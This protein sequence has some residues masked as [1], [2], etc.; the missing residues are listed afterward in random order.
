[1]DKIIAK[2]CGFLSCVLILGVV[3]LGAVMLVP[4]LAGNEVY[5]V[6]SGSMEPNYHVG[7]LVI[8]DK[9]LEPAELKPG[10]AITFRRDTAV[11]THRIV[12]AD[13][14]NQY[15]L[16]KGDA[17][18]VEDAAPVFF[19][20][21][22]GKAGFSIPLAGYLPLYMRTAKGM[23]CIFAYAAVFILLQLIPEIVKPEKE[24]DCHDGSI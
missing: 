1:M 12:E 17:N 5:A 10:D 24:E 2:I 19:E 9:S 4:R 21:V 22:I 11:V 13:Y 14:E 8:V 3:A 18:Q 7:S 16:T 15:F 6:M 20:D 23:F